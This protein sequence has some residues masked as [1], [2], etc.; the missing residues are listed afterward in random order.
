M[1][2]ESETCDEQT[3]HLITHV[4]TTPA[5]VGDAKCTA[6]IQQA[7]A[8]KAIAPA[9]HLADA[10]YIAGDLLVQSQ[11]QHQITLVGPVRDSA[12]WQH[13]VEGAYALDQFTFDWDNQTAY[14][15]QG[16]ASKSCYPFE[17]DNGYA[18]IRVVF[19]KKDCSPCLERARCTRAQ[20]TSRPRSLQLQPQPQQEAIH[21]MRTYLASDE[22]KQLYNQRAGIEGTLLS[23][24]S[25]LWVTAKSLCRTS[26][27]ASPA[28]GYSSG[29]QS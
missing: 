11:S 14:C 24:N 23:R 26:Q 18:Y 15:P 13:H 4:M 10:S 9:I 29:D 2:I 5:N 27:D 1:S 20:D 8:D 12:R 17:K 25:S 7:L 3:P 6:A 28:G 22:G 21:R 19:D 16:H